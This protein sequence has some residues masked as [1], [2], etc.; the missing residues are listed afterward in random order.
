M[1]FSQLQMRDILV[2]TATWGLMIAEMESKQRCGCV[3]V[4][5]CVGRMFSL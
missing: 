2:S 4:R 3:P 1:D 5:V